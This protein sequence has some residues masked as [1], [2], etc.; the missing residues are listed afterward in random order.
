MALRRMQQL[1]GL[2]MVLVGGGFTAWTWH[3]ALNEGYYYAKASMLFPAFFVVGLGLILFPGDE[4]KPLPP[5]EG[6]SG[7]RRLPPRWWVI[8]AVALLAGFGNFLLLG[9]W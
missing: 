8:I 2:L 1:F 6:L 5:S 4:A 9:G 7:L 3:T